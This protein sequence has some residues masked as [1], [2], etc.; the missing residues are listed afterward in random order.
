MS[1]SIDLDQDFVDL[2]DK[3]FTQLGQASLDGFDEAAWNQLRELGLTSLTTPEERGGSGA[4][5]FE[6]FSLHRAAAY[7]AVSL[8]LVEHDLLG[9]WLAGQVDA[10]IDAGITVVGFRS[11]SPSDAIYDVAWGRVASTVLTVDVDEHG[12][13]QIAAYA[14]ADL[15]LDPGTNLAGEPRDRARVPAQPQDSWSVSPALVEQLRSRGALARAVQL[16]GALDRSVDLAVEH[17]SVRVQFGRP[18][19]DF[20][21][22]QALL[23]DAASVAAVA[24]AATL[25]AV[26]AVAES[27]CEFADEAHWAVA[28]AKSSTSHAAGAVTRRAH[29]VLGAIGTTEEHE[30]HRHSTRANSWRMEFGTATDW[31]HV[32][33]RVVR[34]RGLSEVWRGLV[35][36]PPARVQV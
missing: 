26:R 14:A 35:D 17:A 30:L 3:V 36:G 10:A 25:A 16:C 6:A 28:V 20:Q 2:A 5:W 11:G 32:L 1:G 31:D 15:D 29:Q 34:D 33:G 9:L 22:V 23:A 21:A 8:P 12:A 24:R 27:G 19:I 4:T 13:A 7:R 18:L